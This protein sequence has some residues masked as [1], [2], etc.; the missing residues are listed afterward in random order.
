MPCREGHRH[1][2]PAFMDGLRLAQLV[3]YAAPHLRSGRP[4][5][6]VALAVLEEEVSELRRVWRPDLLLRS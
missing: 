4:N 3:G 2:D 1:S 6:Q 5:S